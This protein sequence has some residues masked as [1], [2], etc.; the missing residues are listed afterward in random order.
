MSKFLPQP[1]IQALLARTGGPEAWRRGAEIV[2]VCALGLQA[3]RLAWLAL[4]PPAPLGDQPVV[5]PAPP[6][7][8]PARLGID[9]FH[10]SP[11]TAT[12]AADSSG[13]RL[14]SVRAAGE[15]RGSAILAGGD[16][17][18]GAFAVGDEVRAGVVL[19]AVHRDHVLLDSGGSHRELRFATPPATATG[20]AP[21]RAAPLATSVP[22]SSAAPA[23]A[24][25]SI[26]PTQ[27]IAQAGLRPNEEN[28]RVS[29]YSVTPRG[30][31]AALRQAGL[32]A[33]DVL[34]SVNGQP[35]T[36]ELHGALAAEL[37]RTDRITLTYR[38]GDQTRTT[39]LQAKTP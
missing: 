3:G 29:G 26:D 12:V 8:R 11:A 34:L 4:V 36:P 14:H 19:A 22:A 13:L 10:P 35:L 5:A 9:A 37:A 7:P 2:L 1:A 24:P 28:G 23:D 32:Q 30:D 38:R 31:G 18:Q 39:T 33:G 17:T 27:L 21:M 15:G 20:A 6:A 25:V 16:G